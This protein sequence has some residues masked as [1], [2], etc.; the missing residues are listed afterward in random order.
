MKC[1]DNEQCFKSKVQT[2]NTKKGHSKN[3]PLQKLGEKNCA[4]FVGPSQRILIFLIALISSILTHFKN[5]IFRGLVEMIYNF[6]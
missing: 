2:N 4:L 6:K 5:K 3:R 1:S